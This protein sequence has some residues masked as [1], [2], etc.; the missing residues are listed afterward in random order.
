MP[1]SLKPAEEEG[2]GKESFNDLS[3]KWHTPGL[4]MPHVRAGWTLNCMP[5]EGAGSAVLSEETGV[6]E[7]SSWGNLT[8]RLSLNQLFPFF[9][10]AAQLVLFRVQHF[11]VPG[12]IFL[13]ILG[14]W[15]CGGSQAP[16]FPL[17]LGP[18]TQPFTL[19]SSGGSR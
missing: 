9:G 6:C 5:H 8:L 12:T 11:Q 17:V 16:C 13:G 2:K 3:P 10:L 19:V 14:D 1:G 18:S 15:D 7:N 4:H